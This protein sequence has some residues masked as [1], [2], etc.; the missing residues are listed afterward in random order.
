M[1]AVFW[2]MGTLPVEVTLHLLPS[3][4]GFAI[5]ARLELFLADEQMLLEILSK[6]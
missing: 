3:Q 5:N 2:K 6:D 1:R 4:L